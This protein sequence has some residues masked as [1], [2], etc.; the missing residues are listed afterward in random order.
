MDGGF[1]RSPRG[2]LTFQAA[3][4][5][6]Y[7]G[8]LL[9]GSAAWSCQQ[10]FGSLVVQAFDG[11]QFRICLWVLQLL[12]KITLLRAGSDHVQAQ[13]ALRESVHYRRGTT[14]V[15]LQQGTWNLVWAPGSDAEFQFGAKREYRFL[16]IEYAPEL[17]A[18]A[19]P[20]FPRDTSLFA[21]TK[22]R[23]L[24]PPM[25]EIIQQMLAAPY[26][27]ALRRF[28][29]ENQVREL[30]FHWLV[31]MPEPRGIE[32]LSAEDIGRLLKV[33]QL[34]LDD[35]TTHHSIPELARKAHMSQFKL[36]SGF[37]KVTGMGLFERLKEARLQ[38]A[39]Q[40]LLQ[41]DEMVRHIYHQVGYESIT[42]FI[43]AFRERFGLS[44][45]DYRKKYRPK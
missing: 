18:Q 23:L 33:E 15:A 11:P 3:L 45:T 8:P 36:K 31:T 20:G 32:G 30:L 16:L 37:K 14:R 12:E 43:D 42:G 25:Q 4:P 2:L 38:R 13:V 6:T 9:P 7:Q 22:V 10:A 24:S 28:Y 40:L 17:V 29:F 44:P 1:F 41:T 35:L 19:L 39:K 26:A 27:A 21:E 34:I 5:K